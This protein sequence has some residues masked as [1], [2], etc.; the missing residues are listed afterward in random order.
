MRRVK[1]V[2][3]KKTKNTT[4]VTYYECMVL[5]RDEA[6]AVYRRLEHDGF[7]DDYEVLH[8]LMKRIREQLGDTP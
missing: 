2:K 6:S 3:A 4:P 7:G 8:A 5:S 1:K